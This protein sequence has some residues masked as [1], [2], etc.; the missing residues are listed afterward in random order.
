MALGHEQLTRSRAE[1]RTIPS[2]AHFV[3]YGESFPWVNALAVRSALERSEL[4]RVVL[5]HD[6]DLR[7][8]RHL[9]ELAEH[10]AFEAR[11]IEPYDVFSPLGSIG[12]RL[13]ALHARLS[14]PAARANVLRAA[15]LA[16][17][18]GVYLDLDTVTLRSLRPL[19]GDAMFC[20]EELVAFPRE[21]LRAPRPASLARAF[22]LHGARALCRRL[23]EGVQVFEAIAARYSRALNNAV[24][25][26][27]PGHPLL[28]AML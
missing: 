12:L 22:A 17:E 19:L 18:G 11:R 15:I 1:P 3:W 26:A 7:R 10:P 9:A 4:E 21:L 14:R 16:T 28:V 24:L 20:G 13:A 23:P 27:A 2:C 5:H 25:G 6:A 8:D